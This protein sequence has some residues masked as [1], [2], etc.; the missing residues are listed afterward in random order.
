[1]PRN[2]LAASLTQ[3]IGSL[4][5]EP[6]G[7]YI[8]G[9]GY[10]VRADSYNGV[11]Q[12][13]KMRNGSQILLA[14]TTLAAPMPESDRAR[15]SII[16]ESSGM[17]VQA[18]Q[19]DVY[20]TVRKQVSAWDREFVRH[21]DWYA[22]RYDCPDNPEVSFTV[23]SSDPVANYAEN[24]TITFGYSDT[25]DVYFRSLPTGAYYGLYSSWLG[26]YYDTNLYKIVSGTF[27][28]IAS[29]SAGPRSSNTITMDGS[30]ITV[31]F[32]SETVFSLDDTTITG[33]GDWFVFGAPLLGFSTGGG[34]AAKPPIMLL[35]GGMH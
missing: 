34:A 16:H 10:Y 30:H 19:L 12:V 33:T 3:T 25:I 26:D 6:R 1:V 13:G 7:A 29:S 11:L 22:E 32:G 27:T 21:G 8:D 31:K 14:Q 23:L 15:L 17:S 28:S 9:Y 2:N 24:A 18:Y 20:N 4:V 35:T 5:A